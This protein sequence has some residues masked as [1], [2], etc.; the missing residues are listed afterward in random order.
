MIDLSL[1]PLHTPLQI[2]I[3]AGEQSWPG[4]IPTHQEQLDLLRPA[5][6]AATFAARRPDALLC[7]HV[8]EHLDE[9]QGRRA[10]QLAFEFLNPGGFLRVAVP[11]A[12]FPDPAYQKLV[13]V[14]NLGH[15]ILYD[16]R[17]FSDIFT[18]AGFIVD[19]LE[20]CD[21]H[22]RFHYNHWDWNSGPIYRSLLSDLRNKDK[23]LG[24]TSLI[25]DARR[26]PNST[27]SKP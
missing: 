13:A 7:E 8:W 16:Y 15:K 2:I 21:E 11:D 17:L 12:N 9:P 25:L 26:L 23:K 18:S 5:D 1:H 20:Y 6:W 22:G 14:D 10:A 19:L 27:P 3:G 4:W 24:F